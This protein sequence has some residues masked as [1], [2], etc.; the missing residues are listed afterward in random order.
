MN[1]LGLYAIVV[2]VSFPIISFGYGWWQFIQDTPPEDGWW[3]V[4][5]DKP[6]K[7][8]LLL[9]GVQTRDVPE[10]HNN[11]STKMVEHKLFISKT[12]FSDTYHM[13]E[14]AGSN[15]R[16]KALLYLVA[17][18]IVYLFLYIGLYEI[19]SYQIGVLVLSG[20]GAFIAITLGI[21]QAFRGFRSA[22]AKHAA[23][24]DAHKGN[25]YE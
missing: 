23:N 25:E 13:G 5:W 4:L 24:P 10:F 2:W 9:V 16:F 22:I 15:Q 3:R 6:I 8:S 17:L 1:M 7:W 14:Y 18:P 12:W 20:I 19:L 11:T 21:R